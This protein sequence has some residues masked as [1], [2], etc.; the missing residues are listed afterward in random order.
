MFNIPGFEFKCGP[1]IIYIYGPPSTGKTALC[2]HIVGPNIAVYNPD[3]TLIE[4]LN[5]AEISF[6]V[7]QAESAHYLFESLYELC[8]E[9]DDIVIDSLLG[10]RTRSGF[11]DRTEIY[12]ILHSRIGMLRSAL[13]E[14]GKSRLFIIDGTNQKKT[15]KEMNSPFYRIGYT[16]SDFMITT[17]R[18]D[19]LGKVYSTIKFERSRLFPP[20]GGIELLLGPDGR[21]DTAHALLKQLIHHNQIQVH[22]T[23]YHLPDGVTVQG[24]DEALAAVR[25]KEHEWKI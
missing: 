20:G 12:H 6:D 19:H 8:E 2:S 21:I 18:R 22:G 24:V 14:R 23:W 13:M 10:I 25:K 5:G 1:D 4:R 15:I 16:K 3:S 7:L 11:G 17:K 9:Y